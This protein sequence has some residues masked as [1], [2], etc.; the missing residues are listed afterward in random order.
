MPPAAKF[1][2]RGSVRKRLDKS[3]MLFHLTTTSSVV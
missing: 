3:H 1:R 2:L